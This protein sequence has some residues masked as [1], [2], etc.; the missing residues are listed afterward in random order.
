MHS[1]SSFSL[2][3]EFHYFIIFSQTETPLARFQSNPNAHDCIANR[4]QTFG[5]L[6]DI[7]W[8]IEKYIPWSNWILYLFLG[9]A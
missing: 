7:Q 5:L 3:L 8:Q 6:R 1:F 2:P 4:I 9:I